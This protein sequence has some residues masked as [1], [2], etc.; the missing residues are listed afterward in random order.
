MRQ[1]IQNS[2]ELKLKLLI[3]YFIL[4]TINLNSFNIF[5]ELYFNQLIII[6]IRK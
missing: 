2:Y 4:K 1:D 5:M 3:I 6:I